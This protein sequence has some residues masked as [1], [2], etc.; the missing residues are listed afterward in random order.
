M[1]HRVRVSKRR[2]SRGAMASSLTTSTRFS[3]R[4]PNSPGS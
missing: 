1:G 3:M 2:K 4:I